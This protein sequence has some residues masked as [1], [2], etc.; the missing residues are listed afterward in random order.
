MERE[1]LPWNDLGSGYLSPATQLRICVGPWVCVNW[2]W[3]PWPFM[4]LM[5]PTG[6]WGQ[7]GPYKVAWGA[8]WNRVMVALGPERAP[9]WPSR[10]SFIFCKPGTRV[11]AACRSKRGP[12]Q[13]FRTLFLSFIDPF[14]S[15]VSSLMLLGALKHELGPLR[16]EMG[17]LSLIFFV[18]CYLLFFIVRD[19]GPLTK[20]SGPNPMSFQFLV[21]VTLGPPWKLASPLGKSRLRHC[22]YLYL[23]IWM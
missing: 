22:T 20:N 11:K 17:P 6:P 23:W 12:S 8:Y 4:L 15:G 13:N 16:S 2:I 9:K 7:R 5:P 10:C 21:G 14:S 18:I 3:K 1:F 19:F